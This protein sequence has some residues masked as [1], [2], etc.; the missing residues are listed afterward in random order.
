[1]PPAKAI[2]TAASTVRISGSRLG[3]RCGGK[4]GP[5]SRPSLSKEK[6]AAEYPGESGEGGGVCGAGGHV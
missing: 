4:G 2:M 6:S 5:T 1:M 3:R